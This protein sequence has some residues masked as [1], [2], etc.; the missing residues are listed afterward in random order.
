MLG[1]PSNTLLINDSLTQS[2]FRKFDSLVCCVSCFNLLVAKRQVLACVSEIK[3]RRCESNQ[4][5]LIGFF[6]IQ[7]TFLVARPA[8]S[9]WVIRNPMVYFC[10]P[11]CPK[12]MCSTASDWVIS[13]PVL[14]IIR[15]RFC[16]LIP[17]RPP[18]PISCHRRSVL[19][20][21]CVSRSQSMKA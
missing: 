11:C 20:F 13:L 2:P 21:L 10:W 9:D 14:S 5:R 15:H 18:W 8:S 1:A 4:H 12:N 7:R 3:F 17:Q 6:V 19:I 16:L